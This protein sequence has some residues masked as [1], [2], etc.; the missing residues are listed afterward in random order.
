[1]TLNSDNAKWYASGF[2][3]ALIVALSGAGFFSYLVWESYDSRYWPH[4]P[5]TI[6]ASFSERTCGGYRTTRTW[7][8]KIVYRYPVAGLAHQAS[9]VTSLKSYCDKNRSNVDS[10]LQN[11][12][13]IG[14][15]VDVYYNASRPD[16]AFLRPGHVATSDV[17]MIFALLLISG[18][19][20]VGGWM[21]L[22]LCARRSDA[23]TISGTSS[24]RR[25]AQFTFKLSVGGKRRK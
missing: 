11:H 12:Y 20:A 16:S 17:V 24:R 15:A 13:P 2:F 23:T 6:V 5:G 9:R 1:M 22:R 25:I 21:S 19:M 8:A 14:Q 18:L 10:W 4:S 7:E 3:A